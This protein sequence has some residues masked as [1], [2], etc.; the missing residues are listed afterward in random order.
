M[1]NNGML[2]KI[3]ERLENKLEYMTDVDTD[4]PMDSF[5]SFGTDVDIYNNE[6]DGRIVI[7]ID[8]E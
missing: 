8:E 7:V 6:D 1:L 4:V 3:M 5:S 2:E